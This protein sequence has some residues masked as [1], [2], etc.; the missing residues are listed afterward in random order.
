MS[1]TELRSQKMAR[2][3]EAFDGNRDGALSKVRLTARSGPIVASNDRNEWFL[4]AHLLSCIC[5]DG[6]LLSVCSKQS[7]PAAPD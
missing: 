7:I 1:D 6:T 4:T 2:I 5:T 3:F